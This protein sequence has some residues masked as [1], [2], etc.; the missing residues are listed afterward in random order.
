[1]QKPAKIS[2]AIGGFVLVIVIIVLVIILLNHK[3]SHKNTVLTA[4]QITA[5]KQQITANWETFFLA[6]TTLQGRENVLQ[7]GSEFTQP[8]QAEFSQ[9]GSQSSSA[10]I[11]NI[12]LTNSTTAQVDYALE[13]NGQKVLTNQKGEALFLNN[14]WEVSDATLCQLLALAGNTPTACQGVNP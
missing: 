1:M 9:L 13:L 2:L 10:D 3:K 4:A 8:I 5:A 11:T 12:T 14:T 6:S 7:N